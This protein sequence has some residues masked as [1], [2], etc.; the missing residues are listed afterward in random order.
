ML[1]NE[2]AHQLR[3]KRPPIRATNLGS[4]RAA[5]SR[6]TFEPPLTVRGY[7]RPCL[8][9][10]L[11]SRRPIA[12]NCSPSTPSFRRLPRP[13]IDALGAGVDAL[14]RSVE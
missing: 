11:V 6:P 8:I 14:S 3:A 5:A 4:G 1:P 7:P 10:L 2:L 12:F 13:L 9:S